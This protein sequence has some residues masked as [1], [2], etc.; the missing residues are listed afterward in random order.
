MFQSSPM[1][2]IIELTNKCNKNCWMCG[3]RKME[4]DYPK[5]ATQK[6]EMDFEL[7][8]K[9]SDQLADGTVVQ[10]HNNGEPLMYS[11]L[12]DAIKLFERQITN[13][14]TNGKWLVR[15]ADEIIN[16]LDNLAV[17]L[18]EG[19]VEADAQFEVLVK[20]L[21]LK[22]NKKPFTILKA[23]GDMKLDRYKE[24]ELPITGRYIH[25]PM[26]NFGFELHPAI[27]DVCMCTDFL[28]RLVINWEGKVSPCANFDPHGIHI[29]GDVRTEKLEEIWN[30]SKRLE[31][32]E[33]HKQGRRDKI[34]LCSKCEYWGISNVKRFEKISNN[35]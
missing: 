19:D 25:D 35:K 18:F 30:S 21:E 4:R 28:T 27:P 22:G 26:G 34:P 10:L 2:A 11:R 16:N 3:R 8:K 33:Y 32:L 1:L 14:V 15:K 12:G 24:L 9:I 7:V 17:S 29:I 6:G 23:H 13:I 20:F 5:L 31:W